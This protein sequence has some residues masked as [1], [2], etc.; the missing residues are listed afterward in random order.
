MSH[1][2]ELWCFPASIM[3][4]WYLTARVG[5][6]A[7]ALPGGYEL[8]LPQDRIAAFG[9]TAASTARPETSGVLLRLI[10]DL[11]VPV[12]TPHASA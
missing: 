8:R 5:L 7:R 6:D 4:R 2:A 10:V 12:D 9:G 1:S 3:S 11:R